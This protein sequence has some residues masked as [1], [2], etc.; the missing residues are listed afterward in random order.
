MSD[1]KSGE[2]LTLESSCLTAATIAP[3]LLKN[4]RVERDVDAG[5]M[6]SRLAGAP[7]LA[8][9]DVGSSTLASVVGPD[10]VAVAHVSEHSTLLPRLD[11][12]VITLA[13]RVSSY[14]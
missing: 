13:F 14:A 10:I 6:M 8:V 1:A 11:C 7:A 2:G 5:T 4:E 3:E 12:S 9:G